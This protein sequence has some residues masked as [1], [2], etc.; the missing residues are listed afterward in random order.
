MPSSC[1]RVL[2]VTLD[3]GPWTPDSLAEHALELQALDSM[4][5]EN[6]EH[7]ILKTKQEALEEHGKEALTQ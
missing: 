7:A 1:R 4:G 5:S 3:P 6:V 2:S